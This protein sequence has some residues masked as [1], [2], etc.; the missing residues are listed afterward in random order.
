MPGARPGLRRGLLMGARSCAAWAAAAATTI[1]G[2]LAGSLN[3]DIDTVLYTFI[4]L[5]CLSAKLSPIVSLVC[6]DP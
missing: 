2:L 4:K 1:R 5:G 3:F 6:K